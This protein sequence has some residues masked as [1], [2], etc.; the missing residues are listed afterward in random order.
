MSCRSREW[1]ANVRSVWDSQGGNAL[2]PVGGNSDPR[3][4]TRPTRQYKI[5]H[6]AQRWAFE[7]QNQTGEFD[8]GSERTFAAGLTHASRTRIYP[9]G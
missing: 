3:G 9:S 8:P 4:Q 5:E 6:K 1:V 7:L 2:H